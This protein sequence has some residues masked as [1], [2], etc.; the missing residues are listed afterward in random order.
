MSEDTIIKLFT[1]LSKDT[2]EFYK[3]YSFP[4]VVVK[5]KNIHDNILSYKVVPTL[6][7]IFYRRLYYIDIVQTAA[8][9]AAYIRYSY[10]LF[11]SSVLAL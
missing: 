9:T 3:N 8:A 2:L 7:K 4:L 6:T 1:C 10:Y 5:P 11:C